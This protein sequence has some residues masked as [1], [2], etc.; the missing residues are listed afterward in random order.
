MRGGVSG[1]G[2]Q[3]E[4]RGLRRRVSRQG[5]GSQEEGVKVR[6]GGSHCTYMYRHQVMYRHR[7]W[8]CGY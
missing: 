3:G 2:C 7:P 5:E 1:G 8:Y 6:G 4:G